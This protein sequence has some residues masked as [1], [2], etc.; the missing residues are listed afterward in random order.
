MFRGQHPHGCLKASKAHPLCLV[1]NQAKHRDG[2]SQ[3]DTIRVTAPFPRCHRAD[4]FGMFI[5]SSE[6]KPGCLHLP[7]LQGGAPPQL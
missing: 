4:D 7:L 1:K 3:A 6:K 5:P 2:A